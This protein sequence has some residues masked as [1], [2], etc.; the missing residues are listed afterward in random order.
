[1]SSDD[2]KRP[3]VSYENGKDVEVTGEEEIRRTSVVESINLNKN[4][5]A[6]YG[7]TKSQS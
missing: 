7:T 6:K 1:M 2:E 5:D 3:P 4:L